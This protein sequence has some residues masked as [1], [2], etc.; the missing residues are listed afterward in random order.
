[1]GHT[2]RRHPCLSRAATSASSQVNHIFRRSLLTALLQFALGRPGPL[3]YPASRPTVLAVVCAGGPYGKHVQASEVVFLSVC[4]S[5]F[6]DYSITTIDCVTNSPVVL[7]CLARGRFLS[8]IEIAGTESWTVRPRKSCSGGNHGRCLERGL[9]LAP[10]DTTAQWRRPLHRKP[11]ALYRPWQV[12]SAT[13]TKL[14]EK[15]CPS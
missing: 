1:L 6:Y 7:V 8:C 4:F 10:R 11:A 12:C 15:R 14:E 2:I 13:V 5:C 9:S 3:L